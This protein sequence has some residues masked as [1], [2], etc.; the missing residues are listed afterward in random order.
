M[1]IKI[2]FI[3]LLSLI[4]IQTC[5][6]DDD[7]QDQLV[8][9][10]SPYTYEETKN[11]FTSC[12]P[13]AGFEIITNFH[14]SSKND[15]INDVCVFLLSDAHLESMLLQKNPAA[16]LFLPLKVITW[17]DEKQQTWVSY[18]ASEIMDEMDILNKESILKTLTNKLEHLT[19]DITFAP[20][21][22]EGLN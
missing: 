9:K 2:L 13:K 4:S 16:A 17:E 7:I 12:S 14:Y 19:D 1:K 6:C 18:I 22:I 3:F 11:R 15:G 5:F 20:L 21:P 8:I 10:A